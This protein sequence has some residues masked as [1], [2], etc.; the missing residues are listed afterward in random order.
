MELML[1]SSFV[2]H[3]WSWFS[4]C[5]FVSIDGTGVENA[6]LFLAL[7]LVFPIV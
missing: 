5:A 7:E 1:K 4:K 2:P 6:P 3:R